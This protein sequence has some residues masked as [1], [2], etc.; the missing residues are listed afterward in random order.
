MKI[1]LCEQKRGEGKK[2]KEYWKKKNKNYSRRVS[3]ELLASESKWS[4]DRLQ[5]NSGYLFQI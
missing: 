5:T 3:C 2:T 1:K 4:N